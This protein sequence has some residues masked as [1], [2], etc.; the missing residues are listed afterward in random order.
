MEI[1][2]SVNQVPI[3]LT[4]ERWHHIA[5]C[6]RRPLLYRVELRAPRLLFSQLPILVDTARLFQSPKRGVWEG[7][8]VI[9]ISPRVAM[10]LP[11]GRG[12]EIESELI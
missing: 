10:P 6:F 5:A 9:L 7:R 8:E 12:R 3:R 1:G 11:A 2:I 4:E